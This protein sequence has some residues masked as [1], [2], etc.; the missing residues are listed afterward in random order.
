MDSKNPNKTFKGRR[1]LPKFGLPSKQS[2]KLTSKVVNMELTEKE[3]AEVME[4]IRS[5]NREY[6]EIVGTEGFKEAKRVILNK[7]Y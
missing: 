6:E 1:Y 3:K 5:L 7:M 2:I 4:R